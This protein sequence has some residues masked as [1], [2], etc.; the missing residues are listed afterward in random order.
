MTCSLGTLAAS[1]SATV[2]IAVTP[3]DGGPL[4]NTITVTAAA[5]DVNP[6]NNTATVTSTVTP[7]PL[8]LR[9]NATAFRAGDTLTLTGTLTP[10]GLTGVV[11]AYVVLRL[12]GGD[13]LS[14]QLGGGLVPGIVPIATGFAPFVFAGE[15][16]RVPV[17][18]GVPVG[19]YAWLGALTQAGTLNV[20]GGIDE[21]AFT[22]NP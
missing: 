9:L 22:V 16:L 10:G 7:L 21:A 15:L 17:P 4:T 20:I 6:A 19:G 5:G 8:D 1:A 11:D 18:A 14:L 3:R 12:P 13:F 2:V